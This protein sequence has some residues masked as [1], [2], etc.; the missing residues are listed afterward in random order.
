MADFEPNSTLPAH[1][2]ICDSSNTAVSIRG[3]KIIKHL[4]H[5]ATDLYNIY[6]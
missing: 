3:N 1:L 6:V 2:L 5:I 4:K